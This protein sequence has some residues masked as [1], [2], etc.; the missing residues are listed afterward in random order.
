[1]TPF[2]NPDWHSLT[3]GTDQPRILCG[4]LE[5][6]G[7]PE[8]VEYVELFRKRKLTDAAAVIE[9]HLQEWF[10]KPFGSFLFLYPHSSSVRITGRRAV[11]DTHHP[12][13]KD[14]VRGR[15][16]LWLDASG[17]PYK[18]TVFS[19]AHYRHIAPILAGFSARMQINVNVGK[20]RSWF[21]WRWFNKDI[22]QV[23]IRLSGIRPFRHVLEATVTAL[24]QDVVSTRSVASLSEGCVLVKPITVFREPSKCKSYAI[25]FLSELAQ[26]AY[27][28]QIK[29]RRP[30]A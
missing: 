18:A 6:N 16:S 3:A 11:V 27:L 5:E 15:T 26:Q 20:C 7:F 30:A 1:M 23:S 24:N 4:W 10:G 29:T 2:N 9:S 28:H 21:G 14:Q 25:R 8:M 12:H 17:L 13:G 19:I 22:D